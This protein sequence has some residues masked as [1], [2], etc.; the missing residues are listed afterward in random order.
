MKKLILLPISLATFAP[1]INI[2]ACGGHDKPIPPEPTHDP[3]VT[4]EEMENAISL[5]DEEYLQM[6]TRVE[7]YE[8]GI[9]I[10]CSPIVFH[11]K[12][13]GATSENNKDDY[14]V[15]NGDN[16]E[17]I[18]YDYESEEWAIGGTTA[19]FFLTPEVVAEEDFYPTFLQIFYGSGF[20]FDE[21]KKC[22]TGLISHKDVIA[23]NSYYFDDKKL[24]KIE[25]H[26]T[27]YEQEFSSTID[28]SYDETPVEL[29]HN[30]KLNEDTIKSEMEK[31]ISF[32][33]VSFAQDHIEQY[34]DSE[35][36][37]GD[38]EFSPSIFCVKADENA[39]LQYQ[40]VVKNESTLEY[41]K[42]FPSQEDPGIW[43]EEPTD[44]S[45]MF[46]TERLG[47]QL[48]SLY[49]QSFA[50]GGSYQYNNQKECYWIKNESGGPTDGTY[51]WYFDNKRLIKFY[52]QSSN[53]TDE[54]T[55]TF[56]Y[57]MVTP[58]LPLI[59]PIGALE[60]KND[61]TGEG[62]LSTDYNNWFKNAY[63]EL[64]ID[65]FVADGSDI[66]CF[67]DYYSEGKGH[68]LKKL[69]VDVESV[70]VDDA[71]VEYDYDGWM[72]KIP[73]QEAGTHKIKMLVKFNMN[74]RSIALCIKNGQPKE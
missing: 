49:A 13:Y 17:Q 34:L 24:V 33:D 38:Y 18:M 63:Y 15:R 2:V 5:R 39:N 30:P 65:E 50:G 4:D 74:Y 43:Q 14:I 11:N 31:A 21:Q 73:G 72:I 35:K 70:L 22:Y 40:Y 59:K 56:K 10:D 71:P 57:D 19:D 29:P 28:I 26:G 52:F 64:Y 7:G 58:P 27:M 55:F 67:G 32:A 46:T 16:Y 8:G 68:Q 62:I 48:L 37:V 53:S 69:I 12:I 25:T 60:F 44:D 1:M 3:H 51:C 20:V 66:V 42:I 23:T 45:A 6:F 61:T 9:V 41:T 36:T 47:Q 54:V